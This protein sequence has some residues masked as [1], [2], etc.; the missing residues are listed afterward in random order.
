MRRI[1]F[2][3][4]EVFY[5][6]RRYSV[7]ARDSYSLEYPKGIVRAREGTL[8]IAIFR[9]RRQA[10]NFLVNRLDQE[11]IRVRPI[12]RGKTVEF[13]CDFPTEGYLDSF[14][15]HKNTMRRHLTRTPPGTIFYPAVEVLD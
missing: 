11:I 10:E 2:K 12:G 1:K 4:V 5:Y 14:Y 13:V 7:F 6:G 8:G 9:T 3:V 15:R